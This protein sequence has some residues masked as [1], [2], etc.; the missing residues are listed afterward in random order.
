M[1][2]A[3]RDR[4]YVVLAFLF[5][6]RTV[7]TIFFLMALP[8]I[9][10]LEGFSLEV[11]ALLQL[12]G[13]PYL[14]KF[15]W[16]PLLDR[17]GAGR[18][19]YKRWVLGSG[20]VC[21]SLLL[22]LGT[23]D[24]HHH[25]GCL[26]AL[27]LAI[28]V[29][30]ATQDIAISALYIKLFSFAERGT[31]SSTKVLGLN[32]G[33]ILGSGFFLVVYNHLG[34]QACVSGMG[35]LVLLALASLPLLSEGQQ[36]CEGTGGLQWTAIF[37][38]FKARG[39]VRWSAL[40]ILNSLSLSAVFFI[41]KP[42]LVDRG[43]NTDTIAFLVGFYGMTVAALTAM[44]TGTSR[45]QRYLLRRRATYIHSVVISAA[46][47]ALFVFFALSAVPGLWLYPAVALINVAMTI[48]TVVSATLV[49]D[50][51]R[52]GLASIDYALQMTGIHLGGMIMACLS[53]VIVAA[54]GYPVFFLAQV[55][56]AGLMILITAGLFRG[57]WISAGLCSMEQGMAGHPHG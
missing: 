3:I 25:F 37:S 7:P 26:V 49:M 35:G 32:L 28:S 8:V 50:F 51:S 55:L 12:A 17:G 39:M 54:V 33:S 24:L 2:N 10:R 56:F 43:V 18:G 5:M 47:V 30:T 9:F 41:M 36:P 20:L 45:F 42:F 21:G 46:S 52:R 4:R 11:I 22:L 53:G 19:H 57:D 16:A 13:V 34:W 14:M 27:I 15:L 6:A 40:I 23:L 31:G 44:A 29:A 38:F 48:A 1:M